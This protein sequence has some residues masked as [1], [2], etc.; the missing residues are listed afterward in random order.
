MTLRR[1]VFRL[2]LLMEK[3]ILVFFYFLN[4]PFDF[5]FRVVS[6][7]FSGLFHAMGEYSDFLI[8]FCPLYVTKWFY[9]F[10]YV[11]YM[12]DCTFNAIL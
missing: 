12:I 10:L 5:V 11:I 3:Y 6:V 4:T 2:L 7:N 8:I 1:D 9:I